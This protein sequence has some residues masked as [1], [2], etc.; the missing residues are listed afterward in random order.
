MPITI[1]RVIIDGGSGHLIY[2]SNWMGD[3][4]YE[5]GVAR[6]VRRIQGIQTGRLVFQA[7]VRTI[8]IIP[9]QNPAQCNA[10]ARPVA[11]HFIGLVP[12]TFPPSRRDATRTG[13][14]ACPID[15]PPVGLGTGRGAEV[16]I[17]FTPDMFVAGSQL[18]C[19]TGIAVLS[20][21]PDVALVHEI[22]HGV[23]MTQG[24]MDC[25]PLTGKLSLYRDRSEYN[26]M[27]VE[28]VFRSETGRPLRRD[29]STTNVLTNPL[30]FY[31][32]PENRSM[33]QELCRDMGTF[34]RD[35]ARVPSSFNPL[36]E[37]YRERAGLTPSSARSLGMVSP[38]F[39]RKTS[40]RH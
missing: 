13:E 27:L 9:Q 22:F 5:Q 37:Y 15:Q 26:A 8:R 20:N 18:Y 12:R 29:W 16:V 2:G 31:D 33:I 39:G 28:N 7:I 1:G 34:T 19:A 3:A 17:E 4:V 21:Q 25:R 24:Q 23:Q 30:A 40:I 6:V 11:H 38:L 32:L 10:G 14:P 35:L 36:R